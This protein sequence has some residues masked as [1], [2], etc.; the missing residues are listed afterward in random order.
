MARAAQV[1]NCV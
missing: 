1:A